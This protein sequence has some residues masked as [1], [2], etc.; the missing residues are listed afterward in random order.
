MRGIRRAWIGWHGGSRGW[1]R[2]CGGAYGAAWA[3]ASDAPATQ[4]PTPELLDLPPACRRLVPFSGECSRGAWVWVWF[5]SVESGRAGCVVVGVRRAWVW[6]GSVGLLAF[7]R[8]HAK[9]SMGFCA[10]NIGEALLCVSLVCTGLTA[11]VDHA[12]RA[13]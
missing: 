9:L 12:V 1:R 3:E 4:S 7:V 5:G 8:T 6:P 10:L 2:Q 11:L 13:C